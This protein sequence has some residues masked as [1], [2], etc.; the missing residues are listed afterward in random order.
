MAKR[1]MLYWAEVDAKGVILSM[2]A[3]R[4]TDRVWLVQPH[5]TGDVIEI[6]TTINGRT[7]VGPPRDPNDDPFRR[8]RP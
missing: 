4:G 8:V 7:E 2:H 1:D 5:K 6:K 3:D